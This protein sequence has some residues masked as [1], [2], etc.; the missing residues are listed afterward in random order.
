M[1]RRRFVVW[2]WL[3]IGITWKVMITFLC[4]SALYATGYFWEPARTPWFFALATFAGALI[5]WY[6][7]RFIIGK[8]L[9]SLLQTTKALAKGDVEHEVRV[10]STDEFG[11]LADSYAK[12]I[13]FMKEM[14]DVA[15]RVA[16]G[17]LTV[18]V[19]PPISFP[20][21]RMTSG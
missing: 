20:S 8:P 1:H 7:C 5:F 2:N 18:P 16:D 11:E 12:V 17:D 15:A 19:K 10:I 6:D 3:K 4:V 13:A 14:S 21:L 9:E